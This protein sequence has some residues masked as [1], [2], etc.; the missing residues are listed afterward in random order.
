MPH[1]NCDYDIWLCFSVVSVSLYVILKQAHVLIVS[2]SFFSHAEFHARVY[3]ECHLGLTRTETRT[4]QTRKRAFHFYSSGVV[5]GSHAG[6]RQH[7]RWRR[8]AAD[9]VAAAADAAV[10]R[11]DDD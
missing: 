5:R 11:E 7:L 2:L 1:A 10:Y 6:A 9:D 4:C 3:N 8:R